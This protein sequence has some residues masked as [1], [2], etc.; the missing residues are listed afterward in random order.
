MNEGRSPRGCK[1]FLDCER[2]KAIFEA[3]QDLVGNANPEDEL[4]FPRDVESFCSH[5]REFEMRIY[6]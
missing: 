3:V 6:T 5:Y 2:L 1:H 4:L